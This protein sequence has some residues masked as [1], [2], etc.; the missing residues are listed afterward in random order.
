MTIYTL[1]SKTNGHRDTFEHYFAT[2]AE[3]EAERERQKEIDRRPENAW[4]RESYKTRYYIKEQKDVVLWGI[5]PKQK[6]R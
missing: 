2:R 6:S 5:H 3:A 1:Y 4:F